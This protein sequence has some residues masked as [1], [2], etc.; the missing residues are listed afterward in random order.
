MV[1]LDAI[2]VLQVANIFLLI[3]GIIVVVLLMYLL[4]R[5]HL[6]SGGKRTIAEMYQV[7]I[8]NYLQL[9]SLLTTGMDVPWLNVLGI[10]FEIQGVISTIGEYLL[11]PDCEVQGESLFSFF[12]NIAMYIHMH[13]LMKDQYTNIFYK[14]Q[15]GMRASNLIYAKQICYILVPWMLS[16]L[17]YLVGN[18]L[19][20]CMSVFTF[21][22]FDDRSPSL[23]DGCVATIVFLLYLMYPSLCRSAFA[24]IY[25]YQSKKIN[26]IY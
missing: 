3:S 19:V 23:L 24:L 1:W 10:V 7:V 9:S 18:S 22:G 11:S 15:L 14:L 4:I 5:L 25:M 6:Q 20:V 13:I 26:C 21:R 16:L 2:N 17:S 8:I 12:A